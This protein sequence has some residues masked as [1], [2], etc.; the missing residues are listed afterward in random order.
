MTTAARPRCRAVAQHGAS[1]PLSY[2]GRLGPRPA[3]DGS[4]DD[5]GGT[6]EN[7]HCSAGYCSIWEDTLI[8]NV[9]LTRASYVT[10]SRS[11][12]ANLIQ[13]ITPR[14]SRRSSFSAARYVQDPLVELK[15]FSSG[16]VRESSLSARQRQRLVRRIEAV[17]SKQDR[18]HHEGRRKAP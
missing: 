5:A 10:C 16:A 14:S 13:R 12:Y 1:A 18:V 11:V 8:S 2:V 15:P 3:G 9:I 7:R 6:N 4:S 17:T